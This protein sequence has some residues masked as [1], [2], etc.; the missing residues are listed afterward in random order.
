MDFSVARRKM[1]R[2]QLVGRGIQDS[3]VVEIMS[4]MPRH[5]FVD[6]GWQS[7][8]YEDRPVSIGQGQT[9]SQP[10]M[11][12][13]MTESL[14]L[15]GSERVLEVGTGCGYQTAVL[16]QLAKQVYTIE[17]IAT[18]SN[19]ARK[20]FYRLGY[21]N[22]KLRIGDGS[23]GWPEE[24]PFDAIMVTAAAP[25]VPPPLLNQLK[26][27]GVLIIPR[28]NESEQTLLRITRTKKG[29]EEETITSCRFV[30]LYGQYGWV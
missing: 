18:L 8:V 4:A 5:E 7:Q 28:G 27:G 26:V 1:V 30:K 13:L 21:L 17:R 29:S 16:S 6:V 23:I 20:T 15:T 19:R 24:A 3:R 14:H 2:E 11:V 9:I 25:T 22:I 12:A 10:Y